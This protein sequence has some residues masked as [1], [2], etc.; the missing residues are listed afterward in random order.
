MIQLQTQLRTI[1]DSLQRQGSTQ[2]STLDQQNLR[3][4]LF[5]TIQLLHRLH[6][7]DISIAQRHQ[8]LQ[9]ASMLQQQ[10]N[11]LPPDTSPTATEGAAQWQAVQQSLKAAIESC[12]TDNARVR[13]QAN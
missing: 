1:L 6:A 8:L 5:A 2:F 7:E 10:F 11:S 12:L 3:Q 9:H 13:R 4:L